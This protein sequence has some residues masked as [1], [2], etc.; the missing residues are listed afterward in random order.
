MKILLAI[1]LVFNYLP[2]FGQYQPV[3]R[4]LTV[5]EGLSAS[6]VYHVFQ[7]SKGYIWFATNNGVSR[8]DGYSFKNFDL[9]SGL[10]DNT[11]FEIYEDYKQRI[12]FVPFSGNLSYFENGKIKSYPYNSKIKQHLPNSRGPIKMAFYVD[13]LDNIY[14]GLKNFGLITISAEGIYKKMGEK[15][16]EGE[17]VMEG[18]TCGK[19]LISNPLQA[20]TND[21]I[22]SDE[23]QNF[24][25]NFKKLFNQVVVPLYVFAQKKKDGTLILSID[26]RIIIV[27]NGKVTALLSG[28]TSQYIWMSIDEEE[29]LWLSAFE[30]GVYVYPNCDITKKPNQIL[31][32]E[33]QVTSVLRDKEGSYWFSTLNDGVFYAPDFRI[34]ILSKENGLADNRVN[35]IFADNERV[36][37]GFEMGFVDVITKNG[38]KHFSASNKLANTS[39]I[40]SIYGDTLNKKIWINAFSEL[41]YFEELNY[42][43]ILVDNNIIYP[44]KV[45][46]SADGGLW[47]GTAKGLKKI[48]NDQIIYDSQNKDGF[49]AMVFSLAEEKNGTLWLN[50]INGLWKY[51]NGSFEYYGDKSELLT[52][53]SHSMFFN[54]TDSALW[55]GTNGAGIVIYKKNGEISQVSTNKGL[56]S[57][58]IHQL[59]YS[60]GNVWVATRQG[61]SLIKNFN[62]EIL[63]FT[64]DD[65][66]PSNEVTSVYPS[67]NYVYVGTN[68]GMAIIDIEKLTRNHTPPPTIITKL[69]VEGK[70][71][72]LNDSS[73]QL[74]YNQNTIDLTYVGLAYRNMGRLLYRHRMIGIDTNWAYT[75]STSCLYSGM[76]SGKYTFQI[77][78]L[79]SNGVWNPTPTSLNFVVRP[80]FWERWWFV[81]IVTLILAGLLYLVYLIRIKEIRRRNDMM[82]NIN[83]YKQQSLRQQ[84]NPHFIFNT[85]NSIQ[86]YIL[87]RDTISSHKYLTKFA[88]LMR[89][90]LDNS[91]SPT[92]TLREE[93]DALRIYLELEALRLE[94]RFNFSIDIDNNESILDIKIPTLL[95]QPFVENAIW[96][97]IMLKPEKNGTVTIRVNDRGNVV[98]CSIEDDGV[99]R[100]E[101][102][103]IQEQNSKIHK[104]RGYQ[105]TQQRI[106]LLNSMYKE[107]FDIKIEDLF[108]TSN[109]PSGTRVNITIPKVLGLIQ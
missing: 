40:R 90:T 20:P 87:E 42:K 5:D 24:R 84:M 44:R 11:V 28:Q 30:G 97:G 2:H 74:N 101:A 92:V 8:F 89:M 31:L 59:Y 65:G 19:I 39:Y 94:G 88:R 32:K 106:D 3:Y 67:E 69:I 109:N 25:F 34:N 70:E 1:C 14:L 81:G 36:Y 93:I 72:P 63:N 6:E 26:E 50:T 33:Y 79:N 47:I 78:A 37:I 105:I 41:G 61:L 4:H 108:D 55:I 100:Q 95:I 29:N 80:P 43:R 13:S 68:K 16:E 27:K 9:V 98:V 71:I 18:L 51:S 10:A 91:L 53:V 21:I 12:W 22:Y 73:I 62:T 7:D 86:Y 38:I 46:S 17:I 64:I 48:K 54:P 77:Q 57:N 58:S 56:I 82:N 107:R 45:I 66:L 85:L 15:F 75:K 76:K 52:R 60:N 102:Q 104:S 49:S 83:L 35:A 99:G 23:Q 103:R 96:H